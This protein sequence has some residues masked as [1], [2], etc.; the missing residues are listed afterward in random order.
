[1]SVDLGGWGDG[2]DG[3]CWGGETV[4]QVYF[5]KYILIKTYFL[6]DLK[7]KRPR[8]LMKVL[9]VTSPLL[10]LAKQLAIRGTACL[11]CRELHRYRFISHFLKR[12]HL[13]RLQGQFPFS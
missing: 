2:D 3:R 13:V 6:Y 11:L 5:I 4:I 7:K 12:C 9:R 8:K 10:K 1:M